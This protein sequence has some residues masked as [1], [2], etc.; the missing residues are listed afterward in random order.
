MPKKIVPE[1]FHPCNT[2]SSPKWG[3]AELTIAFLPVLQAP[4][5]SSSRSTLQSLGLKDNNY[6]AELLKLKEKPLKTLFFHHLDG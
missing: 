5:L 2:D 1:P 4:F 6:Q 3:N